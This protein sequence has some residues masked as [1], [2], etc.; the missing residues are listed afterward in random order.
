MLDRSIDDLPARAYAVQPFVW[1]LGSIIGSAMGGFLA[2][3]AIFYPSVFPKDGL[4]GRYPYLLPNL[5]AVAAILLAIIQGII[6]LEETNILDEKSDDHAIDDDSIMDETTPLNRRRPRHSIASRRSIMEGLREES[7]RRP[8]ILEESLPFPV[9]QSFDIRRSSFAT[10]Y[11]I[12]RVPGSDRPNFRAPDAS[13]E[14]QKTFNF[15]V[16]MLTIVTVL[17]SYHQMSFATILPVFLLDVPHSSAKPDLVGGLGYTVHDVGVFMAV[18]GVIALFIQGIVFPFFVEKVGVW[19][20][21]FSL[22]LIYPL[23][24]IFV[25]FLSILPR[26]GIPAGLYVLLT[27]QNFLGI[28]IFPC[29]LILLKNATP[30]PQVLGKV[31]GL[32]MSACC[33]ART[34]GP[35]LVGIIYSAG[36]SAAAMWSTAGFALVG[37]IQ[38]FWVPREHVD[39]VNVENPLTGKPAEDHPAADDGFMED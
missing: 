2:Q 5:V 21:F 13:D 33:A 39:K 3:P 10:V 7:R 29:A 23:A 30:S 35:P 37:A 12:S 24:Y 6:F 31:N 36:G 15:S 17:I 14:P 20:S 27:L 28:I 34:V 22:I 11:S 38:L 16:I 26:S 8:S 4:F 18:N 1:A 25:P 19:R 32:A 9:D